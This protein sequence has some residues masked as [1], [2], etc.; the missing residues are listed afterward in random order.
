MTRK[1]FEVRSDRDDGVAFDADSVDREARIRGATAR[2]AAER[3]AE[4]NA[5]RGI[6]ETLTVH[7]VA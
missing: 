3:I 1:R 6:G 5:D 2:K 7:E 4:E